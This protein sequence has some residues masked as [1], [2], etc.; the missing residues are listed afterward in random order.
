MSNHTVRV[1]DNLVEGGIGEVDSSRTPGGS[2]FRVDPVTALPAL[3]GGLLRTIGS[4][5]HCVDGLMWPAPGSGEFPLDILANVEEYFSIFCGVLRCGQA[6]VGSSSI[7]FL[8][9][10]C[11]WFID[12]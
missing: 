2:D 11:F 5:S 9:L 8:Q 10:C 1:T 6:Q 4:P 3:D 7:V 12:V